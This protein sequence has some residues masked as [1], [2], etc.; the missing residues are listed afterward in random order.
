MSLLL[1]IIIY[2]AFISLGLPDSL[3]GATWPVMRGDLGVPL[4]AA[5]LLSMT[6]AGGTIVSSFVSGKLLKRFGTGKVTFVSVLLTAGALLGFRFAPSLAGLLLCAIPLGLGAGAV[7]VGLND[8]VATHYQAHHM[9]WLHSFWGVGAT[10]GPI[11]MA[12]FITGG[13]S[14]RGGYTTISVIQLSLAV[15]LLLTLPLWKRV[16]GK[17]SQTDLNETTA[18]G[19]SV[20]QAPLRVS[21]VKLGLVSFLC[22]SAAETT[23][24]LWGSSF[25]VNAKGLNPATA[26]QWASLFFA[27]MTVGRLVTGFITFKLSN[28]VLIRWGQVL[29]LLGAILLILPMVPAFSLAGFTIIGLGL[30][31]IYPGMLH[32][33]PDRFGKE[34]SQA[35]MGYQMAGSYTAG[36]FVPP[37][38]GFLASRTTIGVFPVFLLLFV[39]GMLFSS[40]R[41]N[42][43]LQKQAEQRAGIPVR[44]SVNTNR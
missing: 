17:T 15:I 8:F 32:D 14:W 39:V 21:G 33:T 18:S 4:E 9:N 30:A 5:G 23:V 6:V 40:E 37:L 11:I 38:F 29:V 26:A 35:L 22:Y 13:A 7:D 34:H 19:K 43:M 41:L 3:L 25:L 10:L 28:R 36:T 24:M 27:G 16:V 20:A 12:R 1:L 31:P 44:S 2:L 42:S